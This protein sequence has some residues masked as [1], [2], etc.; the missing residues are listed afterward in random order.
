MRFQALP[1][2]ALLVIPASRASSSENGCRVSSGGIQGL[3]PTNAACDVKES[4]AMLPVN[5]AD[6]AP[7]DQTAR[8][9]SRIPRLL[10][11]RRLNSPAARVELADRGSGPVV[12]DQ[13]AERGV[14]AG[15]ERLLQA[16]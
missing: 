9:K 7:F 5:R 16:L 14:E 11:K 2:S 10:I 12:L 13:A 8:F 6:S 3:L 4:S 1:R 15:V